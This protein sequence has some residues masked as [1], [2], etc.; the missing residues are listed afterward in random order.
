MYHFNL[1][2]GYAVGTYPTCIHICDSCKRFVVVTYR[3]ILFNSCRK[4]VSDP[5]NSGELI[6]IGTEQSDIH[7]FPQCIFI[8]KLGAILYNYSN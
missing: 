2:L 1:Y 5:C 4:H 6:L 7:L 8:L 3:S